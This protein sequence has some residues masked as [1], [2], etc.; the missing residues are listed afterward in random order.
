[1]EFSIKDFGVSA[2]PADVD[3]FKA[4]GFNNAPI[5]SFKEGSFVPKRF[6]R[7]ADSTFTTSVKIDGE[8]IDLSEVAFTAAV[9]LGLVDMSA[10]ERFTIGDNFLKEY[11]ETNLNKAVTVYVIPKSVRVIN[12]KQGANVLYV[13][14]HAKGMPI[15]MMGVNRLAAPSKGEL[16]A[17]VISMYYGIASGSIS[18]DTKIAYPMFIDMFDAFVSDLKRDTSKVEAI[19]RSTELGLTMADRAPK[20][21]FVIENVRVPNSVFKDWYNNLPCDLRQAMEKEYADVA[22]MM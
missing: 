17:S 12:G 20:L 10:F 15:C 11:R 1:M 22:A 21:P 3:A 19:C 16:I 14:V 13:L 9:N 18:G 6:T 8:F 4:L 7:N 2:E 5:E